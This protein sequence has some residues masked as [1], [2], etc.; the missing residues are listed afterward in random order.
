MSLCDDVIPRVSETVNFSRIRHQDHA[1]IDQQVSRFLALGGGIDVIPIGSSAIS[2]A[3]PLIRNEYTGEISTKEYDARIKSQKMATKG[4]VDKC[5]RAQFDF[6]QRG[7]HAQKSE[8]GMNIGKNK[9]GYYVVINKTRHC[10]PT[11]HEE[12][13]KLRDRIR[14]RLGMPPAEY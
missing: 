13:I 3:R 6:P 8:H 12:A 2:D 9:S 4:Y 14:I 1:D 5:A 7:E 10:T 11:T